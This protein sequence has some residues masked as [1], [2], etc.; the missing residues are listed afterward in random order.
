[1]YIGIEKIEIYLPGVRSL[2]EKR[3]YTLSLKDRIK[4]ELNFSV[5]EIDYQDLLQRCKIGVCAV[6]GDRKILEIM[7]RK[8][9]YFFKKYPELQFMR[10]G[11]HIEKK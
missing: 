5:A 10:E 7:F 8:L 2:K 6:S 9:E 11:V 4:R 1:M 3:K